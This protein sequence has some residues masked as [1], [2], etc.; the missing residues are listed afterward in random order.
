[1]AGAIAAF[2]NE[3]CQE[4]GGSDLYLMLLRRQ[5]FPY[6]KQQTDGPVTSQSQAICKRVREAMTESDR[7]EARTLCIPWYNGQALVLAF[8]PRVVSGFKQ[9]SLLYPLAQRLSE[10]VCPRD[11]AVNCVL[12]SNCCHAPE[13]LRGELARLNAL[14]ERTFL[15]GRDRVLFCNQ[16][17]PCESS[18]EQLKKMRTEL[19]RALSVGTV[20]EGFL[21]LKAFFA[22]QSIEAVHEGYEGMTALIAQKLRQETLED[23]LQEEF[24]QQAQ[25]CYT[26][27]ELW[28]S[29]E[30]FFHQMREM[31]LQNYSPRIAAVINYIQEH[32]GSDLT[33]QQ[34]AEELG[35]NSEYLNKLFKKEVGVGFSKYLTDCRMTVA[36]RLLKSGKWRVSEVAQQ[37]GYKSSQYFSITF[38]KTIGQTPSQVCAIPEELL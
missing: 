17:Q 7:S 33:V 30:A 10:C 4:H 13:F 23:F 34:V 21:A 6:V 16:L 38:R 18:P 22:E 12:I 26:P 5:G 32:Y 28:Q 15:F 2:R 9:N 14:E 31:P 11:V 8:F 25:E 36:R 37:V 35:L 29:F 19:S 1:N 3:F 24:R 27:Q 20:D